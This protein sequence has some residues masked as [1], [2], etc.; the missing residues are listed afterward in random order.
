MGKKLEE[1][2]YRLTNETRHHTKLAMARPTDYDTG[3]AQ[4]FAEA[5]RIV[6]TIRD[7]N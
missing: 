7:S 4:G 5:L 6:Q 1:A 3:F 2:Y